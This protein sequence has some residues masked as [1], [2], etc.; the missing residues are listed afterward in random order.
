MDNPEMDHVTKVIAY[1]PRYLDHYLN[2]QNFVMNC[3]GPLPFEYRTYIAIMVSLNLHSKEYVMK[4][5]TNNVLIPEQ[6][7]IAAKYQASVF[8]TR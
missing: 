8:H 2:T 3:D 7:K 5:F 6:N 1:H 4:N